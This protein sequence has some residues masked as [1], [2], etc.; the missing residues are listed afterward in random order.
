MNAP[1]TLELQALL[2]PRMAMVLPW[3]GKAN[4]T[5]RRTPAQMR[6][7]IVR[8]ENAVGALPQTSLPIRHF[9]VAGP[10]ASHIYAREMMIPAGVTLVGRVHKHETLSIIS[11]GRILIASEGGV[12]EVSAPFTWVTPAGTKRAGY[13]I[14]ETIITTLHLTD[15]LDAT[16]IEDELGTITYEQFEEFQR[17]MGHAP[18]ALAP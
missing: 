13:A 18:P 5:V 3:Y 11:K 17:E 14:E 2:A 7:A 10:A 4:L 12:R 15:E 9:Y 8:Y 16:K 6:A 1:G